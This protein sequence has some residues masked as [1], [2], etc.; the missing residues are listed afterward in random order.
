[1][2]FLRNCLVRG[3]NKWNCV[4]K[5]SKICIQCPPTIRCQRV[6]I[7]FISGHGDSS[8]KSIPTLVKNIGLVSQVACGS[9]HTIALSQDGT[10]LW[11]FGA[12]DSGMFILFVEYFVS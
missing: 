5:F 11:S 2:D 12:G 8:S 9:S 3:L 1:M 10:L 6:R 4:V 7:L